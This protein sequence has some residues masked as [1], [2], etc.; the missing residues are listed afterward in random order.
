MLPPL[1]RL[2]LKSQNSEQRKHLMS[3]YNVMDLYLR[4]SRS[5]SALVPNVQ[6]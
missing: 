4:T 3:Y 6:Q 1:L 2:T 5:L